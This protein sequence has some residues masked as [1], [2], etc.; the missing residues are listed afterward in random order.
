MKKKI[1]QLEYIKKQGELYETLTQNLND[2]EIKLLDEILNMEYVLTM[3]EEGHE[4]EDL[5]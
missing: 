2:E 1:T 5:I 3:V 4:L